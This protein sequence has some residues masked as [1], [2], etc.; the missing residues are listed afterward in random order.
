MPIKFD[1][2]AEPANKILCIGGSTYNEGTPQIISQ[3]LRNTNFLN[4]WAV[5][6][7]NHLYLEMDMDKV[8]IQTIKI[9]QDFKEIASRLIL[10]KDVLN[11]PIQKGY[12]YVLPDSSWCQDKLIRIYTRI[13]N[14]ENIL[15]IESSGSEEILEEDY[16][17]NPEDSSLGYTHLY[18][19]CID[20]IMIQISTNH[21]GKVA[22]LLLAGL[23]NDGAQGML[24]IKQKGGETAVQNPKECCHFIRGRETSSMPEAAI[25]EAENYKLHHQIISL[26]TDSQSVSDE[27]KSLNQWLESIK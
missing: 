26:N 25:K 8:N 2:Q 21:A 24:A 16:R 22:G 15:T 17:Y 4:D 1:P 18:L 27:I 11:Y 12:F 3:L 14:K 23:G 9:C 6:F 13:I 5:I 10:V 7:A 20:K 19:P